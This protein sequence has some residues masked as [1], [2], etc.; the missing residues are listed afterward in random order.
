MPESESEKII[1]LL[2]GIRR[3]EEVAY[4]VEG[5]AKECGV[6]TVKDNPL[7]AV[8]HMP[9]VHAAVDTVRLNAVYKLGAAVATE[10]GVA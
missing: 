2:A 6:S 3:L 7:G 8:D 10:L 9:L 5:L 4:E 1:E